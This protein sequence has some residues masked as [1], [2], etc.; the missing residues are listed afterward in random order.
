MPVFK[1]SGVDGT[2]KPITDTITAE[3]ATVARSKLLSQKIDVKEINAVNEGGAG[4]GG[5]LERVGHAELMTFYTALSIA[6]NAGASLR[7]A[8]SA[9][10]E[11]TANPMLR[12]I[13][14]DIVKGIEQGK[15]FSESLKRHTNLFANDFISLVAAGEKAGNM[16]E[17]LRDYVVQAEKQ[18]KIRSKAIGAMIYP[19]VM[20]TVAVVVVVVLTTVIFPKFIKSFGIPPEKL[21]LITQYVQSFSN[22]LMDYWF[23]LVFGVPGGIFAFIWMSKN[24]VG[25]KRFADWCM[26]NLPVL[27]SLMKKYYISKFVHVLGAQLKG[28]VPGLSALLVVRDVADNVYFQQII[29]DIIDSIKS[30][31]TYTAPLKKYPK[32]IPPVVCL[33]FSIGERSG[34]MGEVLEKIGNYYDEQV[35]TATEV[36]VSLI[37]PVMIVVMGILVSVIAVSMF[38]PI[39]NLTKN[40]K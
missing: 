37:E 32:I 26:F 20:V 9:L 34:A 3:N 17:M 8:L 13:L 4:G 16:A 23:V 1:F 38:L 6:I 15:A 35:A 5:F 19:L 27:G 10:N 2:G 29:D 33:M 39:F 36:M 28:G 12:R 25:G 22:L 11:Q 40:M 30:G 7:E 21:P 14:N 31:G 24:T 18:A